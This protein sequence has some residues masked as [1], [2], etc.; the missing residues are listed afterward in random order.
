MKAYELA[1]AYQGV[2]QPRLPGG[3]LEGLK[4]DLDSLA[5]A[6]GENKT[7][8]AGVKGYTGTQSQAVEDAAAWCSAIR[9]NLKR[10]HAP[11]DVQKAAGVGTLFS[12]KTV[13]GTIPLSTPFFRPTTASPT[14]F[15]RRDFCQ[16]T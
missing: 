8:V 15:A 1:M 10:G 4:E 3:L 13:A 14:L 9:E 16:R 7:E 5:M 6:G 11:T 12:G 2:L